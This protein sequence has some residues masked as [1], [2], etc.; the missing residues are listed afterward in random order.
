ML[1]KILPYAAALVIGV[2]AMLL[3]MPYAAAHRADPSL[4]GGEALIPVMTVFGVYV[5][6]SVK[7][8]IKNK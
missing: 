2:A 8:E 4:I 1:K 7:K 3:A 6:R 5:F